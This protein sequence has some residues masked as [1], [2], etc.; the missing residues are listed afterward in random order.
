MRI[1]KYD[2]FINEG[3]EETPEYRIKVFFKELEKNIR[4]WFE[5]GIFKANNAVLGKIERS[6]SHSINKD[7]IFEFTDEENYY[8]VYVIVSLKDVQE[9]KLDQC[10][11]KVKKYDLESMTLLRSLG[12]DVNISELNEDKIIELFAK[13]DEESDT[14]E[15]QGGNVS[16]DDEDTDLEDTDIE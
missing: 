14:L 13:L 7:L 2:D 10:Y 11:V 12:E 9:D 1:Y 16:L 6:L 4:K 3:Y 8:Q 5:D 15:I